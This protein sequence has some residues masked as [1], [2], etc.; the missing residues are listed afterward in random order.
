MWIKS[1]PGMGKSMLLCGIIDK[2]NRSP[3]NKR[4]VS[5]FFRQETDRWLNATKAVF[6]DLVYMLVRL[7]LKQ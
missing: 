2:L 1:G 5:Y 3:S 4:L 7:V 6:R